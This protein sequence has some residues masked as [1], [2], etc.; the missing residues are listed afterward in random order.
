MRSM[1]FSNP[2]ASAGKAVSQKVPRKNVSP[3]LTK[4][5]VKIIA[6]LI[7][8]DRETLKKT[9]R[10]L[11]RKLGPIDMESE[12]FPFNLTRYYNDE[13]GED[14][15]RKFISFRKLR[16]S[17]DIYKLKLFTNKVEKRLS[18]SGRRRINID[19]GYLTLAKL[20]LFTTKDYSHRIYIEDGIYAEVTLSFKNGSYKPWEWTYPDY[21]TTD[22]IT[23]F[24]RVRSLYING[25]KKKND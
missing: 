1:I 6:G 16:D 3:V 10:V 21:K 25:L 7:F 24:N 23:F 15:K 18:I 4:G 14:L 19:P 12:I 13:M 5:G 17:K 11:S 2:A 22:Y 9:L 8:K 20:V